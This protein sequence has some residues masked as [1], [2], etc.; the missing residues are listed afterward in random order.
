MSTTLED[1]GKEAG[2]AYRTIRNRAAAGDWVEKRRQFQ[3][4]VRT[5]VE[6][7]VLVHH[8][9][10]RV[11][12]LKI[13]D[14]MK[15]VATMS[16]TRLAYEMTQKLDMRLTTNETRQMFKDATD[17]ERAALG[18]PDGEAFDDGELDAKIADLIAE[19]DAIEAA[20]G[21]GSSEP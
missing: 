10:R 1:V 11:N 20:S 12:M 15:G 19:F 8:A 14:A 7:R 3:S 2:C 16:L 17:I 9:R 13:A 18:I 6:S 21:D 4:K 5:E